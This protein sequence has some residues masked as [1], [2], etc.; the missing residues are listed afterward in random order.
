MTSRG[1]RHDASSFLRCCRHAVGVHRAVG[2]DAVTRPKRKAIPQWVKQEAIARAGGRCVECN[3]PLADDTQFDH[4]P[5][6]IMRDVN[7]DGDDYL[8]P[9]NDPKYIDP[10]HKVCHLR[11]TVGRLPGAEKTVTTKGSDAWLAAKFRKLEGKNKPKRKQSIPS[12]PFP[13]RRKKP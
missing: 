12:R 10:L 11:R 2:D 13:N 5:A 1:K 9:Q 8:P 7:C 3:Q 4:R 6:I